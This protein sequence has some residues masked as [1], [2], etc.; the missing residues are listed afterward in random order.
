MYLTI[1]SI[2]RYLWQCTAR[3]RHG[4]GAGARDRLRALQEIVDGGD[5]PFKAFD[6][7]VRSTTLHLCL[8]VCLADSARFPALRPFL[9][10]QSINQSIHPSIHPPIHPPI[11][12][13]IH[14][15]I[16][17]STQPPPKQ[18]LT[19]LVLGGSRLRVLQQWL[20]LLFYR[21]SLASQDAMEGEVESERVFA[22]T[23]LV[24]AVAGGAALLVFLIAAVSYIIS[25]AIGWRLASAGLVLV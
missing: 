17:S 1:F 9:I 11:H 20:K 2:D 10:H 5:D 18:V 8:H 12:P 16:H 22:V 25:S 7:M 3:P 13:S 14:P 4:S 24:V 23:G 21:I 19:S 6:R 15:S